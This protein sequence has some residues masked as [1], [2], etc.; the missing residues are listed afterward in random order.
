[1]IN[2]P[3]SGFVPDADENISESYPTRPSGLFLK[4][5]HFVI[6]PLTH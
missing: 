1:M 2:S 5:M 3:F 6:K 4:V